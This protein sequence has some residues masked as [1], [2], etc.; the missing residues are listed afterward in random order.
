MTHIERHC[1]L[2]RSRDYRQ[3][4]KILDYDIVE[5]CNC[6]FVFLNP[7]PAEA[8]PEIYQEGYFTGSFSNQDTFNISGWDY[9]SSEHYSEVLLHSREALDDIEGFISPGRILDIGCG[10]GVFLAE[11]SARGWTPY[12]FDL[13]DFAVKYA[14]EQ[15]GLRNVRKMDVEHIDYD[16][17]SFE[18]ISLFHVIEHVLYPRELIEASYKILKQGGILFIETPDISTRRAKGAGRDWR[19]LKI[20]EHLNY[21][22]IKTLSK[23]LKEAGFTP[24]KTKRAVESTGLMVGFFGGEKKARLFYDSWSQKSWF[25]F[26][27]RKIRTVKEII[28]GRILRDYDKVTIIARKC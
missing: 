14:V 26:G 28:S 5:C 1:N 16:E 23:L 21:F 2:C 15:L 24:L 13:S 20:P 8:L 19:Y 17:N 7:A 3:I 11:A 6:G 12:G 9:F 27:V 25:R 4:Y 22:S 18:A 10:P